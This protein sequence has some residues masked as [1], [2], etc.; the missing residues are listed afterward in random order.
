D[1]RSAGC[2]SKDAWRRPRTAQAVCLKYSIEAGE[3]PKEKIRRAEIPGFERQRELWRLQGRGPWDAGIDL[4][5]DAER[6]DAERLH[7]RAGGLAAGNHQ[8]P[9]AAG[10]EATCDGRHRLL[11]QR[12][13]PLAT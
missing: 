7:H 13:A 2:A 12:A 8:A 9:H 11:H 4:R 6:L 3:S 10:D 1:E 5:P